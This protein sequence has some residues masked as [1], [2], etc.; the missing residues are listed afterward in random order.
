MFIIRRSVAIE[1]IM[2]HSLTLPR[3]LVICFLGSPSCAFFLAF[4]WFLWSLAIV[5]ASDGVA[6][7]DYLR[8][9]GGQA[10]FFFF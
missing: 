6:V 7:T 4:W 9:M 5:A 1:Q 3:D 8:Q 10:F 2:N